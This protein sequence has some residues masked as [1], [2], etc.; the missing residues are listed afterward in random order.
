MRISNVPLEM[1]REKKMLNRFEDVII[2]FIT[3]DDITNYLCKYLSKKLDRWKEV[4][5][6][7]NAVIYKSRQT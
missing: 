6:V 2:V 3:Y 7:P 5:V 1:K 4:L